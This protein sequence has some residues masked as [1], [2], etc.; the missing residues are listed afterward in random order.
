MLD[1]TGRVNGYRPNIYDR[2]DQ[3]TVEHGEY[4]FNKVS[5]MEFMIR[6]QPYYA[7]KFDNKNKILRTMHMSKIYRHQNIKLEDKIIQ[8]S[9]SEKHQPLYECL[10]CIAVR[11]LERYYYSF[12][13]Q[14]I[15]CRNQCEM[16]EGFNNAREGF[17]AREQD[18]KEIS[19][20]KKK[21]T[22]RDKQLEN[23]FN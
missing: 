13:F 7:K 1:N 10:L 19:A 12:L 11:D 14:Y 8:G 21:Y 3:G 2:Y 22:E 15:S 4:N 9:S 17:L 20:H 5:L 18:I 6:F 23:A 16:V